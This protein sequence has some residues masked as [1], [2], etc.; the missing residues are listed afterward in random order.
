[1]AAEESRQDEIAK[2]QELVRRERV[3]RLRAELLLDK[4]TQELNDER[5]ALAQERFLLQAF[6]AAAPNVHQRDRSL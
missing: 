2:L 4:K 5:E 3:A 1:M 6:D